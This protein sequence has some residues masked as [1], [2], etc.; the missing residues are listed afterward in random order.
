MLGRGFSS[1][2]FVIDVILLFLDMVVTPSGASTLILLFDSNDS[3]SSNWSVVELVGLLASVGLGLV[4]EFIME[5]KGLVAGCLE[6][7]LELL[8][9]PFRIFACHSKF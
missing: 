6:I 4:L 5:R 8:L 2:A 9:A 3:G 1:F 7:G